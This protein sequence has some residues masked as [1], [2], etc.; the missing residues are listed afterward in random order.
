[1]VLAC[2]CAPVCGRKSEELQVR[3]ERVERRL[4]W[5]DESNALFRGKTKNL[6]SFP[7]QLERK[8]LI[9]WTLPRLP[10]TPHSAHFLLAASGDT[11]IGTASSV[12]A[13]ATPYTLLAALVSLKV[14][15]AGRTPASVCWTLIDTESAGAAIGTAFVSFARC[16]CTGVRAGSKGPAVFVL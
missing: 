14:A 16:R 6:K 9:S 15:A 2:V 1:M 12:L 7:S 11:V 8:S 5:A 10:Q 13:T 3:V 4:A